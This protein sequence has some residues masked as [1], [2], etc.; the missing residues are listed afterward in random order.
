MGLAL[1]F[2]GFTWIV[3]PLLAAL[4]GITNALLR[5][6]GVLVRDELATTRT[7]PQLA[8]LVGESARMGLLDRHEHDLLTRALRVQSQPVE[9]LTVPIA[10]AAAVP[11]GASG[12]E[13]TDVA[14]RSGHLRLVVNGGTPD[15][16]RGVLHVRGALIEPSRTAEEL[17]SPA[18]RVAVSTTIPEAVARLQDA[19][20]HLGFVT[21]ERDRVV[22]LVSLSD[23]IGELL[24]TRAPAGT[25]VG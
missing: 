25:G 7:P 13:I 21:D 2:R 5:L 1:P 15:D 9:R 14:A 17:M 22:G 4:N 6:F 24:N 20:A 12:T 8:M 23:L 16:V 3:R 19:R 10:A 11:A 18:P